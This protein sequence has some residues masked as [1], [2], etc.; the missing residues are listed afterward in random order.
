MLQFIYNENVELGNDVKF[1][2]ELL[3]ASGKYE[4]EKLKVS[5]GTYL[6]L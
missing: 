2:E 1:I 6:A 4:I 3:L 5:L